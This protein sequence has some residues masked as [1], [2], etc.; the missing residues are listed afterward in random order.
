VSGITRVIFIFIF[1]FILF[2]FLRICVRYN[3]VKRA[4]VRVF[5]SPARNRWGESYPIVSVKRDLQ[6]NLFM[7]K[8]D[9]LTT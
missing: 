8:R 9:L 3:A 2:D 6:I 4:R 1:I 5:E 7:S